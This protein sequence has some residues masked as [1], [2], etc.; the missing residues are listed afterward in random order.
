MLIKSGNALHLHQPWSML[1]FWG[2]CPLTGYQR[3]VE[4]ELSLGPEGGQWSSREKLQG[5]GS[6][7]QQGLA[8]QAECGTLLQA[9]GSLRPCDELCSQK[10]GLGSVRPSTLAFCSLL[11]EVVLTSQHEWTSEGHIHSF[12]V[13]IAFEGGD[14]HSTHRTP[15]PS[16][17]LNFHQLCHGGWT[18]SWCW[19]MLRSWGQGLALPPAGREQS[20]SCKQCFS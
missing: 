11:S 19:Q 3:P 16:W 7:S 20:A 18:R 5:G 14:Y 9:A 2:I 4:M 12:Q 1:P 15:I 10:E 8:C 13:D 17:G 6:L